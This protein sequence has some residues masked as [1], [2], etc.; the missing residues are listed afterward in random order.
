MKKLG[1]VIDSFSGFTEK[2]ANGF[3]FEFLP[4]QINVGG[5]NK[6][7]GIETSNVEIL[8]QLRNGLE[9]KTSLPPFA[10][11]ETSLKKW[12]EKYDQV[13][14]LPLNSHLSSEHDFLK[15]IIENN[16]YGDKIAIFNNNF[17]A[18]QFVWVGKKLLKMNEENASIDE[19]IKF[20]EEY[21]ESSLNYI[22]PANLN[23]LIQSGRL[24]K[25]QKLL[26]TSLKL[27]PIIKNKDGISPDTVKRSIKSAI[28]KS[29]EKLILFIGGEEKI[30]DYNFWIINTGDPELVNIATETFKSYNI[31]PAFNTLGASSIMI[32]AGIDSI[33]VGVSKHINV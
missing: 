19:M 20:L 1:I 26:L 6:L 27:I 32:H 7:E 13:I 10:Y 28:N 12:Y 24:K 18:Y 25:Y 21:N 29:I 23:T 5:V 3:G 4:L 30:K 33:S 14:I 31:Y 2:E 22:I 15:K 16:N 17:C 9:C 8:V 11:M